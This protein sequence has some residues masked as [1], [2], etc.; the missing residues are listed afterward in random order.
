MLETVRAFL[1]DELDQIR[2]EAPDYIIHD[3]TAPWG[4][5][6]SEALGVPAVSSITTFAFNRHVWSTTNDAFVPSDSTDPFARHL[7]M[8]RAAACRKE[9]Q[10]AYGIDGPPSSELFNVYGELNIVYTTRLFQPFSETFDERFKFVGPVAAARQQD[11]A[12]PW[13]RLDHEVLVY[14]SLGTFFN[15]DKVFFQTCFEALR[16]VDCQLVVSTGRG[17]AVEA[18][19][20]LPPNAVVRWYVPQLEVLQRA[21]VFI[22]RGGMNS[23]SESLYYGVPVVVIPKILEQVVNASRVQELG[24]GVHLQ[25]QDVTIP[26]LRAAVRRVLADEHYQRQC[27]RIGDSFRQAGGVEEAVDHI[28]AF[29][30]RLAKR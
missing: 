4:A 24:A 15:Q 17:L 3:A 18:L 5:Y 21:A 9:I 11:V 2:E 16:D 30:E 6:V 22:T 14:V 8:A 13:S 10:R 1:D 7:A 26:R 12:F 25:A 23:I 28:F 27:K 29:K 20:P 19:G